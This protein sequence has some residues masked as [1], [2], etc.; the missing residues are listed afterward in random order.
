[1]WIGKD[2]NGSCHEIVLITLWIGKNLTGIFHDK[3][4]IICELEQM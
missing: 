1:M 4:E 2:V 3:L